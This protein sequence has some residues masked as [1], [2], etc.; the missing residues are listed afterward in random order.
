[1]AKNSQVNI[2]FD[3]STAA[4]LEQTAAGLGI[5]TSALVRHLTRTFLDDVKKTGSV[6]IKPQ[7]TR[8]LN[9]A[10]ARSGWGDRKTASADA[11]PVQAPH[12]NDEPAERE[13]K[14]AEAPTKYPKGGARGGASSLRD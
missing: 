5:S 7:W 1:M 13:A 8:M 4:Q 9:A 10:D 6:Q 11:A 12:L 2:R 3:D 14:K